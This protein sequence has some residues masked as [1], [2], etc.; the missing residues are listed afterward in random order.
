MTSRER[1]YL[2]DIL[3]NAEDALTFVHGASFEDIRADKMM[4][5]AVL[6]SLAIIGEAAGRIDP[7]SE[8]EIPN[9]P[10]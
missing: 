9:L 8:L 5:N 4:R 2:L 1:H 6:H 3:L 7:S 10:W